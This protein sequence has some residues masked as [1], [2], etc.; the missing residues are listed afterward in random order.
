VFGRSIP[1]KSEDK[2]GKNG[3]VSWMGRGM[4]IE[5]DEVELEDDSKVMESS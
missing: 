1:L 2:D 4:A 5:D 3:T